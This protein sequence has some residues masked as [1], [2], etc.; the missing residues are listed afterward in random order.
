MVE[1]MFCIHKVIGSSPII[2]KTYKHTT[3]VNTGK[4]L[5]CAYLRFY[6]NYID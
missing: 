1:C 6:G 2:S 5:A 4:T 3:I